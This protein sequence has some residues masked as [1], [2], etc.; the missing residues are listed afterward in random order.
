MLNQFEPNIK[1]TITFLKLLSVKV[2]AASV[3]ETLQN[4]IFSCRIVLFRNMS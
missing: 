1:A 3:N 4:H 2:N